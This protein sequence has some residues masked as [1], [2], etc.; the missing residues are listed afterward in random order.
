LRRKPPFDHFS[1]TVRSALCLLGIVATVVAAR[2]NK[3]L[4]WWSICI[5]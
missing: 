1:E 5:N 4:V 3:P 2:I